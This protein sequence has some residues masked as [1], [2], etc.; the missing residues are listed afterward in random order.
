MEASR[1]TTRA[2]FC[3]H[4]TIPPFFIS[5][6]AT[7]VFGGNF[8]VILAGRW[9]WRFP[10][11]RLNSLMARTCENEVASVL[12]ETLLDSGHFLAVKVMVFFLGRS[13]FVSWP[14]IIDHHA[15]PTSNQQPINNQHQQYM[16]HDER[17]RSSSNASSFYPSSIDN[18][19]HIKYDDRYR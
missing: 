6:P 4:I 14:N 17:R 9:L 12:A 10:L 7:L 5:L 3:D 2:C 18:N 13:H 11:T 15:A 19:I 8:D 1:W 16:Y